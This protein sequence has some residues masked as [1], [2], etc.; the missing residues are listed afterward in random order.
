[1][2]HSP[3]ESN[4]SHEHTYNHSHNHNSNNTK[5]YIHARLQPVTI[6]ATAEATSKSVDNLLA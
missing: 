1:M 6:R 4:H 3:Y 5:S 2:C